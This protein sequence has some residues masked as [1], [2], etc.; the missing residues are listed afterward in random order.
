MV[1]FLLIS[2][3]ELLSLL[4]GLVLDYANWCLVGNLKV[5]EYRFPLGVNV[6]IFRAA[7]GLHRGYDSVDR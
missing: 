2:K 5:V 1:D 7:E 3:G 6:N 4:Y